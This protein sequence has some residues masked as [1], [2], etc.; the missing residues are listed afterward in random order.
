[1]LNYQNKEQSLQNRFIRY[2]KIDTQSDAASLTYP[3]TQ[4]QKHL[5]Y[6]LMQELIEMGIEDIHSDTFGYI[7]ATIPSNSEKQ[8]PVICFCSHIDTSPDC[9]GENVKP[10]IHLNYQGEDRKSVV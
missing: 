4:K 7:Y 1:M 9:S 8:V 10:I 2:A 5:T 6:V 3:S